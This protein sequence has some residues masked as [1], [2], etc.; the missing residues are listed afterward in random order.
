MPTIF[1]KYEIHFDGNNLWCDYPIIIGVNGPNA[2]KLIFDAEAGI[3]SFM[4]NTRTGGALAYEP[5]NDVV[6]VNPPA[7]YAG[8]D[9]DCLVMLGAGNYH[10]KISVVETPYFHDEHTEEQA[11]DNTAKLEK[12]KT[13]LL[14]TSYVY[15]LDESTMPYTK[16][17]DGSAPFYFEITDPTDLKLC[18]IDAGSI[19]SNSGAM[20]IR[21]TNLP[22]KPTSQQMDMVIRFDMGDDAVYI[23]EYVFDNVDEG[24]VVD[25]VIDKLNGFI[26]AYHIAAVQT[27]YQ[28]IDV[29]T[30]VPHHWHNVDKITIDLRDEYAGMNIAIT[31]WE[32][33]TQVHPEILW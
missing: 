12:V 8:E 11:D 18:G 2:T 32:Y 24:D 26:Q 29:H 14:A 21:L 6:T 4:L 5:V 15:E 3:E 9:Y 13:A 10:L 30:F 28:R 23:A 17:I 19:I 27:R 22:A 16:T 7:S 33:R 31:H 1:D 25:I 20:R